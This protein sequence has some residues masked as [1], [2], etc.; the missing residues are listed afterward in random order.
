[1]PVIVAIAV[2][3]CMADGVLIAQCLYYKVRNS[4]PEPLH[5]RRSSTETADPTTPLLGRRFSESLASRR[6]SS[7]S[8]RRYHT[9]GRR[10]SEVEDTLAKIVEENDYGRKAWIKNFTSVVGIFLI[11]ATG[12]TTAWQT[13]MWAP[14][15]L[16]ND[17]G[18]E[19]AIG[20]V[21]LGYFSA[22]CYLG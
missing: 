7:G 3:F 4:R 16:D 18:S 14:A 6:R 9:G 2:Y 22:V 20:G 13:G 5:R 15:P 21:V 8:L 1:M 17:N 19:E 10:E 11:G 12:W